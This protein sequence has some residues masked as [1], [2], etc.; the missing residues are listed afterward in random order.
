ME[1]GFLNHMKKLLND[2]RSKIVKNAAFA[3]SKF[4]AGTRKQ[5]QAVI[6]AGLFED[7]CN[8]MVDGDIRAKI[9]AAYAVANTADCGTSEQ[10]RYLFHRVGILKPFCD[11]I[12]SKDEQLDMIVKDGMFNFL[13][14]AGTEI[15]TLPAE[16][17]GQ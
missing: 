8:V 16:G 6:D 5:V 7:L 13:K 12:G 4:T 3:I 9:E 11:L 2:S 17:S 15:L 10:I 14:I 1:A